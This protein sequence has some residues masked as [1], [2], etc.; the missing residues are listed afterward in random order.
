MALVNFYIRGMSGILVRKNYELK[1]ALYEAH[2]NK[3]I[4]PESNI[5]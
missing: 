1:I 5:R 4:Q 3:S 2:R